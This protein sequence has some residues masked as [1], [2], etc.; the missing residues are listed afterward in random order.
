MPFYSCCKQQ[1]MIGDVK[2]WIPLKNM[3]KINKLY[4]ENSGVDTNF[5]DLIPYWVHIKAKYIGSHQKFQK[6]NS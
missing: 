5:M 4:I 2:K 1:K 3:I 6:I